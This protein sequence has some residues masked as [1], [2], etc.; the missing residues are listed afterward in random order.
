M[1]ITG[2][3]L[4]KMKKAKKLIR[5]NFPKVSKLFFDEYAENTYF[6]QLSILF[7]I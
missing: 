2:S 5:M 1:G 3:L 7:S 4:E 6:S